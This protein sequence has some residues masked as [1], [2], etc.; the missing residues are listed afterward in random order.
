MGGGIGSARLAAALLFTAISAVGLSAQQSQASPAELEQQ[1]EAYLQDLDN[2]KHAADLY[3][4]AA[5]LRGAGDAV[6]VQDLE[7]AARLEFYQGSG[8]QA[9]RDLEAAGQRALGVG[10]IFSAAKAFVDAAWVA[11][12]DGQ[13]IR[14]RELIQTVQ[15][16]AQSPLLSST[17]RTHIEGRLRTTTG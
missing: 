1:A 10:D 15:L 3:R 17:E 2:W 16:L 9:V 13:S 8:R 12:R 4:Q 6:A 5:E 11:G 7:T 14:A